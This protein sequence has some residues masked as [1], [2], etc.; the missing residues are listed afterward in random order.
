MKQISF[1]N[2]SFG[3]DSYKQCD[4]SEKEALYLCLELVF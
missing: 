1:R 4:S 3:G 2:K